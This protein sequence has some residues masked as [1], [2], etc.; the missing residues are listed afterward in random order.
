MHSAND[1]EGDDDRL[2]KIGPMIEYKISTYIYC[3]PDRNV[4]DESLVK[5][6]GRLSYTQFNPSKRSWFGVKFYK[7]NESKSGYCW[8]FS[9]YCG[10]DIHNN[11]LVS[12]AV[13]NMSEPL[14]N[15]GYIIY[16][17]NWY[18]SPSLFRSLLQN[19]TCH[20]NCSWT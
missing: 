11:M 14:L 17:D 20:R 18:S 19:K 7:L 6:R 2:K 13:M 15:Q 12:E 9:V 5:C 1:I 4:V 10:Q 3:T 8:K 16:L